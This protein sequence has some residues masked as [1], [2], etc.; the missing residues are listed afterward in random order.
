[1]RAFLCSESAIGL[2]LRVLQCAPSNA[3]LPTIVGAR[4]MQQLA[5]VQGE[6]EAAAEAWRR[7][8][9]DPACQASLILRRTQTSVPLSNAVITDKAMAATPYLFS[10][11]GGDGPTYVADA[12]AAEHAAMV[13][14]FTALWGEA[15]AFFRSE[16]RAA[17]A[18]PPQYAS[19]A[20]A[21]AQSAPPA[22]S[23]PLAQSAPPMQSAPPPQSAPPQSAH[24][25]SAGFE[26]VQRVKVDTVA[27]PAA[28]TPPTA[29]APPNPSPPE[30]QPA[31]AAKP[32][33]E[34]PRAGAVIPPTSSGLLKGFSSLRGVTS[35]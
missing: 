24:P 4:D 31:A 23:A 20:S 19:Q 12:G 29:S 10:R 9:E 30:S 33:E 35:N 3:G 2:E 22:R 5:I 18:Q 26:P 1:L 14:E 16:P 25:L 21:P 27:P 17:A 8:A 11:A 6:I 13:E 7:L 15:A 28:S 32:Q 34:P